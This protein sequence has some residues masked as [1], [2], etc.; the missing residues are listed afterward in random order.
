M[1]SFYAWYSPKTL[2]YSYINI[3]LDE[4]YLF[5]LGFTKDGFAI[6]G[7]FC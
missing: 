1:I 2:I 4:N 3:K 5:I 6:A 7:F